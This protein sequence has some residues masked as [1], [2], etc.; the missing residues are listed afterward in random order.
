[1]N[2]SNKKIAILG[3]GITGQALIK[4]LL[5]R[6]AQITGCDQKENDSFENLKKLPI[7]LA[8]GKDYLKNLDSYDIIFISPG[9]P[10]NLPEIKK[11]K[12]KVKISSEI[13]LFFDLCPAPIIGITG[14][15]G[16]TTTITL[17]SKI[18][19]Q[20]KKRVFTG[21]NIGESL[22]NKLSQI[23]KNDLVILEL[24]SFQLE[25]LKK[26]PHIAVVLNITPDHLDRY[27]NFADYKKAKEKIIKYQKKSD[28]AILNMDDKSMISLSNKTKASVLYFSIS[29][30][31][32]CGAFLQNNE[33]I[34]KDRKR[35]KKICQI[36]D[37]K[38]PGFH[39]LQNILAASLIG[40]LCGINSERIK[41]VISQFEGIEH[42]LEFV[43]EI[44]GVKYFNDSKAT[45]PESTIAAL[46]AFSNPIIL[47]AGGYNK[48]VSF[49]EMAALVTKKTKHLILI[50]QTAKKIALACEKQDLTF[51]SSSGREKC[52]IH[53]ADSL[54]KAVKQAH[55]FSRL[56]DIVLLSPA[57]ASYDMFKNFKERGE[58]F[59]YS[60]NKIAN[61]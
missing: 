42:R 3:L 23:S 34:I 60:V 11:V 32:A 50:G 47:I 54:E 40:H 28:F 55:K 4:F 15:N 30:T 7:K 5:K 27:K 14:T 20:G 48:K 58:K 36:S 35:A 16:K 37:I 25:T 52:K 49:L 43:R 45:T 29:K 13:K 17:A 22:I 8:L 10:L 46:N 21:G 12:N 9:I 53:F 24:S 18:L 44:M 19:K 41:K 39:N 38:L 59:K 51:V 1:M 31:L 6:K 56:G 2:F 26:S 33:I 57:C 61:R